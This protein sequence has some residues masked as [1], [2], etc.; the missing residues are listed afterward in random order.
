MKRLVLVLC[1]TAALMAAPGAA[2]AFETQGTG[3]PIDPKTLF[4]QPAL[5]QDFKAHSLAMPL[6]GK[7]DSGGF[8][9]SYGNSIPIPGPGI[10]LPAPAWA[11][12]PGGFS[13]R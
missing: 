4:T 1:G 2:S 5:T 3:D 8:V 13:L 9:S 10:D 11:Y 6:S 7:S 12:S